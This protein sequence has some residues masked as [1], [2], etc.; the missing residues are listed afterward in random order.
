MAEPVENGVGEGRVSDGL[1]PMIH[2]QLAGD[3]GRSASLA[4]LDDFQQIPPFGR[5]EYAQP[6]IIKDQDVDLG[7][8]FE[9]AG[10]TPISLGNGEGLEEARNT[11][12][13]DRPTVTASLVTERAGRGPRRR[14]ARRCGGRAGGSSWDLLVL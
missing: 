1:V 12:I 8:R 5:S 2:W 14:H 3:D 9:K 13:G 10:V 7:E 11:E 4:V 6:P